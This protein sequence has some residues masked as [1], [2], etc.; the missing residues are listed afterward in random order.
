MDRESERERAESPVDDFCD[1]NGLCLL[2]PVL[3]HF[4][5]LSRPRQQP[6]DCGQ[7]GTA[8]IC[9]HLQLE[10]GYADSAVARSDNLAVR[11][12]SVPDL[13]G[14]LLAIGLDLCCALHFCV[15]LSA[16]RALKRHDEDAAKPVLRVGSIP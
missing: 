6:L 15:R 4:Q 5:V 7:D 9:R 16:V 10:L 11:I 2:P 14:N 13:E 1:S 8:R 12:V 3:V